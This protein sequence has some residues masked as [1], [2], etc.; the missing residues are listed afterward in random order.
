[1]KLTPHNEASAFSVVNPVEYQS[2]VASD[3]ML[4]N[5]STQAERKRPRGYPIQAI[6]EE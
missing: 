3:S 4:S 6:E 1:M 2:D 5:V